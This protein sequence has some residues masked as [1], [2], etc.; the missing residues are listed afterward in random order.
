MPNPY[1]RFKQFSV[2]HDKCAMKVGI[3]GVLIGAWTDVTNAKNILDVGTGSGLISLMLAQRC[4]ATITAI[5]IDADAVIQA[6]ENIENSVWKSRISATQITLQKFAESTDTKFDLIV[7][8]P[9][10]F[11][12]ALKAP[13]EK[14]NTA[15][16]T[17]TLTHEEL[18]DNALK[19]ISKNGR[20]S[21]ILPIEEGTKCIEYAHSKKL[22]CKRLLKVQPRPEKPAHRLLIELTPV[23]CETQSSELCIE[24]GERHSYS[25]EFTAIASPYYLKL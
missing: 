19:L 11:I 23:E 24:N 22:F 17:D 7:S 14:R 12:N 8:N 16:H 15:R 6:N 5:D 1:F 13:E 4:E 3:D 2:F 18:I 25:P 20:I 10:F 9:P 21:I